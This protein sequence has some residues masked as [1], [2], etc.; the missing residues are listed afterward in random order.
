MA[1]YKPSN[2]TPFLTSVD[3]KNEVDLVCELNTSNVAVTAY[4]LRLLDTNNNIV[5]EGK[6]FTLLSDV[7]KVFEDNTGLNG[8]VFTVPLIL[9]KNNVNIEANSTLYKNVILLTKSFTKVTEI[10]QN[11]REIAIE[12]GYYYNAGTFE[13]PNYQYVDN[14]FPVAAEGTVSDNI[15]ELKVKYSLGDGSGATFNSALLMNGYANQPYKWQLVLAQGF[16]GNVTDISGVDN[17]WFDMKVTS[18]EVLGT[19]KNRLQ[20]NLSEEIYRDYFVQLFKEGD[21]PYTAMGTTPDWVTVQNGGYYYLDGG[22]YKEITTEEQYNAIK[23][24]GTFYE[25]TPTPITNRVILTSYDHSYGYAYPEEGVFTD[26]NIADADF[27]QVYK[28]TNDPSIVSDRRKVEYASN[29][30]L[31]AISKQSDSS[32]FYTQ[33]LNGQIVLVDGKLAVS[34]ID[35]GAPAD[36][37]FVS[38][39]TTVLIKDMPGNLRM[40]NGVFEFVEYS[41][42]TKTITWKRWAAADEYADFIDQAFY[43]SGGTYSGNNFT[44]NAV[45]GKVGTL[46]STPLIFSLERPIKIYPSQSGYQNQVNAI[47]HKNTKNTTYIRPFIGIG[48]QMRFNY[49]QNGHLIIQTIDTNGWAITHSDLAT[50][51]SPTTPYTITSCYKEGD[52]NPFYAYTTPNLV[53]TITPA[54]KVSGDSL[55]ISDRQITVVAKYIQL[56]YKNWSSFSWTL[57]NTD[58]YYEATQNTGTIYYGDIFASFSGLNTDENYILA[59]TVEDELGN[60]ITKEIP[61]VIEFTTGG[62]GTPIIPSFNCSTQTIDFLIKSQAYIIPTPDKYKNAEAG[63]KDDYPW[64]TYDNEKNNIEIS[65]DENDFS[66]A[67]GE[68]AVVYDKEVIDHSDR[69]RTFNISAPNSDAFT[70]NMETLLNEYYEEGIVEIAVNIIKDNTT[71]QRIRIVLDSSTDV[72]KSTAEDETKGL[73]IINPNRNK[74]FVRIYNDTFINNRMVSSSLSNSFNIKFNGNDIYR[75]VKDVTYAIIPKGTTASN[76]YDY[77]KT[78]AVYTQANPNI[79][80]TVYKHIENLTSG[81]TKGDSFLFI[82]LLS[83]AETEGTNGVWY[84]KK[85][86]SETMPDGNSIWVERIDGSEVDVK[87]EDNSKVWSD[88]GDY[89]MVQYENI[90]QENNHSGREWFTNNLLTFNILV[91]DF[92]T[93]QLKDINIMANCFV[94]NLE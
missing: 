29:D 46:D 31:P 5:F 85:Y 39:Q 26:E 90:N 81:S 10:G 92:N 43:I 82:P 18:G 74:M 47:L 68:Y 32:S 77:I 2:A 65:N 17:R 60:I 8:S 75:K 36:A 40:F 42:D 83:A 15:Y 51:L 7:Q 22:E 19:T 35:T 45:G 84:D 57:Q 78:Q 53:V 11:W 63:V 52:E 93:D 27:F 28:N 88:I 20:A 4:K 30:T 79:P 94:T 34:N 67:S 44:S 72:I 24:G 61:L 14:Y 73:T 71:S 23:K 55:I 66:S 50:P 38:G 3:L 89:G 6:D 59:L 25:Y 1:I 58:G 13:E 76:N 37:K 54:P 86:K 48:S 62:S 56:E 80:S 21:T 41:N 70:I 12:N 69:G 33:T 49:G 9:D 91:S 64:F 16:T 87:W